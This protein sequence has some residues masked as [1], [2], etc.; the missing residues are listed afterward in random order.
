[1]R[2]TKEQVFRY[3]SFR[4]YTDADWTEIASWI[5]AHYGS[6]LHRPRHPKINSDKAEFFDWIKK[7]CLAEGDVVIGNGFMGAFHE[8]PDRIADDVFEVLGWYDAEGVLHRQPMELH[9]SEANVSWQ[10]V[11]EEM[12][13]SYYQRL[14]ED[15]YTFAI[16][17]GSITKR[18]L[19][20]V[21]TIFKFSRNGKEG[22]GVIDSYMDKAAHMAVSLM[23]AIEADYWVP[24][25]QLDILKLGKKETITFFLALEQNGMSWDTS[26]HKLISHIKRAV[27]GGTYWFIND[28]FGI[29]SDKE[30]GTKVDGERYKN[31]NYFLDYQEALRFRELIYKLRGEG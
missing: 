17:L 28:R 13:K 18:N 5:K 6:G 3:V 19:P 11:D 4:D 21:N 7:D 27:T 14:R 30:T 25:A 1:M 20:A 10:V 31:R 8:L 29:S 26:E 23:D 22:V 24:T 12:T 16:S 2:K 9:Y 15:G